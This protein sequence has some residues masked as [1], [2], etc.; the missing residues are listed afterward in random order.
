MGQSYNPRYPRIQFFGF[1][2]PPVDWLQ[3]FDMVRSYGSYQKLK[4][5]NP[6]VIVTT[7]RDWNV[8]DLF[9]ENAPEEWY[10]RDSKGEKVRISYGYL[11]DISEY[12]TP[13]PKYGGKKYNEYVITATIENTYSNPLYDGFFCQGV[14]DHPY[15]TTDVDLDKNGINDWKEHG[16]DWLVKQWIKGV[17]KVSKAIYEEFQKTNKVLIL[18]SG[19]LHDFAWPYSNGLML[20]HHGPQISF[21]YTYSMYK[22]WMQKAPAPHVLIVDGEGATKNSFRDMRYLLAFTLLGDGYFS[23]TDKQ[24]GEHNYKRYY[25][26]FDLDLG[27]PRSSAKTL[28]NG[29]LIRFFDN[30]VSIINPTGEEKTVTN[31]H[32]QG[33]TEYAGPYYRF[34]GGQ[35]PTVNNGTMFDQVILRGQTHSSWGTLGDGIILLREPLT[36]I[37][38]IIIDDSDE[39]TSP[40]Q[41]T[42]TFSGSWTMSG[43]S[44]RE[45]YRMVLLPY[46]NMYSYAYTQPGTGSKT[47][48]YKPFIAVSGNYEIFEWHGYIGTTPEHT[49]E[50]T[51]VPF[52]ISFANGATAQGTIDQSIRYGQWNSLGTYYLDK[53]SNNSVTISDKADGI[54]I[55]DAFKFVWRGSETDLVKPNAP[56]EIQNTHRTEQSI[57]LSWLSPLPASDGDV[58]TAYQVFRNGSLIAT[59]IANEYRDTGL[60]E[61]TSY[62]YSVYAVD[63]AGLRSDGY[64]QAQ[65]STLA[66]TVAP[67]IISLTVLSETSL[68]LLFSEGLDQASAENINNYNIEPD[69]DIYLAELQPGF[70]NVRLTTSNHLVNYP[71]TLYLNNIRDRSKA[72]NAISANSFIEYTGGTGDTLF[73]TVSVDNDY[74]IWINGIYYGIGEGWSVSESYAAPSIAGK[75]VI[76]IKAYDRGGEAGLVATIDFD[77]TRYVSNETWKVSTSEEEGWETIG[78]NDVVWQKATSHGLHGTALP[79]AQYANVQGIP[80]D[81]TVHWIWTSDHISDDLVYLRFTIGTGRNTTPPASPT[82]VTVRNK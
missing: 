26:E 38:D 5:L 21:D 12:C 4:E 51:N 80:A 74:E 75:N 43:E 42:P 15:G 72:S 23:F 1:T 53:N 56:R 49:Q 46:A 50:A 61:S 17:N 66:D 82:G 18:N 10:V 33:Y 68:D 19:R 3:K 20:E 2:D 9:S 57:T 7:S 16:R 29:C 37:A 45:F 32:L 48:Q 69:I 34:R 71:Y 67:E 39:A 77:G 41:V 44:G 27:Y 52:T 28:S 36:V 79:W 25:D 13:S 8:W 64:V 30:G 14:W 78:F 76:A 81:G 11:M 63:N 73:V 70:T 62:Q 55:A 40:A 47:A 58:A 31:S 35:D 65:Y 60:Q 6:D 54:V 59:P 24:S 22:Q